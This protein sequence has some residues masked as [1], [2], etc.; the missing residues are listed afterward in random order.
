MMRVLI[1]FNGSDAATEALHDLQYAGLPDETEVLLL[2]IS[3]TWL[4]PKNVDEAERIAASGVTAISSR[5]P[6]WKVSSETTAGSPPREILARAGSFLPDLIVV[7]EPRRDAGQHQMFIGHTSQIILT[8]AECS[9]RIARGSKSRETH[10]EKIL[11]GFDGSPTA[12]HAVDSIARR[13]WRPDTEVKLLAV[14]DSSVLVSIGRFTPQMTDAAVEARLV[15]Q[16]AETLA[17]GA[18][19]KLTNAGIS[20]LVDVVMGNPKK[21]IVEEAERWN[22][23]TIFVGPHCAGNSFERFL[24]GSVSAAAAAR[25]HCSV[26]VVRTR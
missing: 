14:A 21:M 11:V 25:A 22:A 5:F 8:E 7:G 3:E 6:E 24:I 4:P 19:A 2:T 20:S 1:G 23:D 17:A 16:W 9:V 18:R 15:A 10:P 13:N 26:E 12:M